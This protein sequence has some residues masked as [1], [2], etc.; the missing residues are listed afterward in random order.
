MLISNEQK[1]IRKTLTKWKN[2]IL[3]SFKRIPI[4]CP[5]CGALMNLCFNVIT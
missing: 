1:T 5:K 4:K 2:L 3:T